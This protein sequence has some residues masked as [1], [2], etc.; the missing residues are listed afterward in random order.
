MEP[1]E[2][3]DLPYAA[4]LRPHAG[5][6]CQDEEY[7]SVH[8]DRLTF[9]DAA[10]A[11]TRFIECALTQVSFQAGQLRRARFT[12]VWLRHVRLMMT[13][14]AETSWQDVTFAESV[15]AGTEAFAARLRR[16]TFRGCKLDSVNFRDAVLTDVR[17]ENCLLREV[18]FG[19][20][21]LRRTSFTSSRLDK[22][23][24]SRVTLDQADLR[25]AE[26][27]I[28]ISPDSL[29]GAII[30]PVQLMAVAPLLAE[31]LGITVEDGDGAR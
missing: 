23:D 18:D 29:R 16:V 30:T 12:D 22:T 6:L 3:A 25:G 10:A 15:L 17:F 13:N 21:T 27:G 20:A 2:L 26:L 4:A 24:F 14:L 7:D 5:G 9:D 8:F 28:T 1:R 19:G 31:T 11:S